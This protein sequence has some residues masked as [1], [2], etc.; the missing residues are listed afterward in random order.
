M[1][2][3]SPPLDLPDDLRRGLEI[4]AAEAG[5]TPSQ[6]IAEALDRFGIQR[7]SEDQFQKRLTGSQ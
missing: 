1:D 3:T 4:A 7:L 6:I 2:S 5:R